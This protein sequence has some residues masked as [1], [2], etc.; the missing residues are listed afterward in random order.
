MLG[1]EGGALGGGHLMKAQ[2]HL[3]TESR[4]SLWRT[5]HPGQDTVVISGCQVALCTPLQVEESLSWLPAQREPD[6]PTP[7]PGWL[8]SSSL[9]TGQ[10]TGSRLTLLNTGP[11]LCPVCGVQPSQDVGGSR[12][13][14]LGQ[15]WF[16]SQKLVLYSVAM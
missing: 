12:A 7:G 3:L 10:R 13:E 14:V 16:F 11:P 1:S 5:P 8:N 9:G 4:L 6:S 2:S 15:V